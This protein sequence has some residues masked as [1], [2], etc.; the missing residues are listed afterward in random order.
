MI[1]DFSAEW[2]QFSKSGELA[3]AG[4]EGPVVVFFASSE[5][6]GEFGR[7][8][9]AAEASGDGVGVRFRGFF[10][11]GGLDLGGGQIEGASLDGGAAR[12]A[13]VGGGEFA[14]DAQLDEVSRLHAR[15]EGVEVVLEGFGVF[16]TEEGCRDGIAAVF[17]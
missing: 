1:Q 4:F 5:E 11:V 14:D 15:D 6:C 12:L 7:I 10:D 3:E 17:E 8:D 9:V 16:A 2:E 13:P